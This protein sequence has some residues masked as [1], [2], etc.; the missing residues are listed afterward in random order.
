MPAEEKKQLWS[1]NKIPYKECTECHYVTNIKRN[2]NRHFVTRPQCD[3]LRLD[4]CEF[5]FSSSDCLGDG[6]NVWGK[7]G[8]LELADNLGLADDLAEIF[9][10]DV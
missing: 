5:N 10:N 3:I 4:N 6:N 9:E 2:Y 7:S 8:D 1:R